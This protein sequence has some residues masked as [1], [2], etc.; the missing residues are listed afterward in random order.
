MTSSTSFR[1]F[2][3]GVRPARQSGALFGNAGGSYVNLRG[4][5]S[6]RTLVLLMASRV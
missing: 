2:P 5:G 4:L 6:Q 3:D 1:S